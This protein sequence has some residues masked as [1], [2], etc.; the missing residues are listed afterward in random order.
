MSESEREVL[1]LHAGIYN[2]SRGD[3]EA[4]PKTEATAK[5]RLFLNYHKTRN[6]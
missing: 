1:E 5:E 2:L 6:E 3:E 4:G